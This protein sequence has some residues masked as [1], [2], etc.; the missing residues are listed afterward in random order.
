[1]PAP[2]E[3]QTQHKYAHTHIKRH[4]EKDMHIGRRTYTK[5]TIHKHTEIYMTYTH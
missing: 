4:K 5:D 1:M 2:L 3:N